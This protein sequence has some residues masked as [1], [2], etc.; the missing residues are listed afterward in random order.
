MIKWDMKRGINKKGLSPIVATSILIVIVIVLAIIILLWARGFI[1]EAVIKEIAGS[2]KRAEEFCRE[3]GMRGFVNEDLEETFGFEN[4]GTIPI[5]AY[6]IN[7][8]ESGSS[9]IIRVGNEK[10]GS[11]NPGS[12]VIITD[13]IV[14]DIQPYSSY[15]SVKI[16]PVL[17]GK[18]EGSTQSY[19]CPEIN[20]ID[21]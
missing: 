2:S 14:K 15:D 4:T 9:K 10:G 20:G 7:L 21:I 17:L 18:V 5:F 12:I 19:D 8:E 11:V 16:I 3:I 13:S 1:K 6:R